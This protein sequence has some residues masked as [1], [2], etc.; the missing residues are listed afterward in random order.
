MVNTV[1][2][3]F[4]WFFGRATKDAPIVV[5]LLDSLADLPPIRWPTVV[6][7]YD[8]RHS[9]SSLYVGFLL[10]AN[11]FMLNRRRLRY[12]EFSHGQARLNSTRR[13]L[14]PLSL[15]GETDTTFGFR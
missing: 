12:V 14:S 9:M 10:D 6:V 8:A 1:I 7:G 13:A 3:T 2:D 11:S 5:A 15:S 4:L